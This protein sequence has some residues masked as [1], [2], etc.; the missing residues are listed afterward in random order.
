MTNNLPDNCTDELNPYYPWNYKEQPT[1]PD[2]DSPLIINQNTKYC[3]DIE[4]S[5]CS[6]IYYVEL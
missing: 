1:C 6:Y 2:C 5:K 3:T 4:C